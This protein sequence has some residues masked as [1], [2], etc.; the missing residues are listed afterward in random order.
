MRKENPG[1]SKLKTT[2]LREISGG[3]V[4]QKI[5]PGEFLKRVA[6]CAGYSNDL[7]PCE[8]ESL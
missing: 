5:R 4:P 8:K 3:L 6:P 1:R 7:K 2:Q